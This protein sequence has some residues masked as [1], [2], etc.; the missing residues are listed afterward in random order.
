MIDFDDFS[1]DQ[2]LVNSPSVQEFSTRIEGSYGDCL[3]FNLM[4]FIPT[5]PRYFDSFPRLYWTNGQDKIIEISLN[6][7][8]TKGTFYSTNG[9]NVFIGQFPI[10]FDGYLV[11]WINDNQDI[12][13]QMLARMLRTVPNY[14]IFVKENC[15]YY[16]VYENSTATVTNYTVDKFHSGSLVMG[17]GL[18]KRQQGGA[19]LTCNS[20]VMVQTISYQS[21]NTSLYSPVLFE[22]I[23][24]ADGS[25]NL[26]YSV[27]N[28]ANGSYWL[29]K[30]FIPQLVPDFNCADY[31][32]S[33][34]VVSFTRS[35]NTSLTINNENPL[36]ERDVVVMLTAAGSTS[37]DN[38]VNPNTWFSMRN[39]AS[40]SDWAMKILIKGYDVGNTLEASVNY[41]HGVIF[42]NCKQFIGEMFWGGTPSV[43]LSTAQKVLFRDYQ[44]QSD[45][46][47]SACFLNNRASSSSSASSTFALF[48]NTWDELLSVLGVTISTN[49]Y[50][51]YYILKNTGNLAIKSFQ[52][53]TTSLAS[54]T[55]N[56][57]SMF[58]GQALNMDNNNNQQDTKM[59]ACI[60]EQIRPITEAYTFVGGQ[61]KKINDFKIF[62]S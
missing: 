55:T 58:I 24:S 1:I 36:T 23:Q 12:H 14:F 46:H 6:V 31:P 40:T 29:A 18:T 32:P 5:Y 51:R 35:G 47:L 26:D 28:S 33:I 60:G 39:C 30:E 45:N 16:P 15:N 57:S 53:N 52:N 17:A 8:R 4:F 42:R 62:L 10:P 49:G 25:I 21:P 2:D 9:A 48:Y 37:S 59:Y 11:Y 38:T 19:I 61:R 44:K 20:G 54:L 56:L 7:M 22:F 41:A 34:E 27:V 3:L 50:E 13:C 43:S